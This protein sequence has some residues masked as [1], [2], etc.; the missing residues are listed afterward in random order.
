MIPIPYF[1]CSSLRIF[2][3]LLLLCCSVMPLKFDSQR[4][5]KDPYA[6]FTENVCSEH[7]LSLDKLQCSLILEAGNK[8]PDQ[9]VQMHRL[10]RACIVR[11]L[12]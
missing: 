8:G 10:I 7:S 6:I 2:Y 12:N 1:C 5:K 9:P 3:S 4:G 11:I